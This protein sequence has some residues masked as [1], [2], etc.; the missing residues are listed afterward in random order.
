M[1]WWIFWRSVYGREHGRES[2]FK[3]V[4]VDPEI[5]R[6]IDLNTI[7]GDNTTALHDAAEYGKLDQ[8]TFCTRFT[9]DCKIQKLFL[10][11]IFFILDHRGASDDIKNSEGNGPYHNV[12]QDEGN[13]RA[14]FKILIKN[15]LKNIL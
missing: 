1:L 8:S 11:G 10:F 3:R 13:I 2:E 6:S 5:Q 14:L 4:D 15:I 9:S 7:N 12:T